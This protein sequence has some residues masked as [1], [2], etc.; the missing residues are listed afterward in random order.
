[1]KSLRT[2]RTIK[3]SPIKRSKWGVGKD[4]GGSLYVHMDY[5]P[6]QFSDMVETHWLAAVIKFPDLDANVVRIDY[7]LGH[8]AFYESIEFDT[9][10]EPAGGYVI[11][12]HNNGHVTMRR[13]KQ[14]WHHKWLFVGDDYKGFDVEESYERS[15]LWLQHEVD[16]KRI[17]NRDYWNEWLDRVGIER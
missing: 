2:L 4:I 12:S 14:I 5:V 8:V 6:F 15:K 13:V 7:R 17:G 10:N 9:E 1:M 11:L 16:S 3:G